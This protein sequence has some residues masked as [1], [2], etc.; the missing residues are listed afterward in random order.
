MI[1]AAIPLAFAQDEPVKIPDWIRNNA[2]WWSN[3]QISDSDFLTGIQYLM[4]QGI[5]VVPKTEITQQV[6]LPSVPGWIKDTAGW[7]AAGQVTDEDF[8]NGISWLV[9]HGI[10]NVGNTTDRK[11]PAYEIEGNHYPIYQ[12]QITPQSPDCDDTHLHASSGYTIDAVLVSF[13]D[14]HPGGCGLGTVDSLVLNQIPMNENQ[15]RQ[16]EKATGIIIAEE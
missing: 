11:I 10:I 14:P 5:M 13:T 12:F 9:E 8:V 4:E 15:I 7:W 1:L 3:G 6:A 2:G 16:W